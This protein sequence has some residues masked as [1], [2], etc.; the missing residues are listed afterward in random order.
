MLQSI[1][2]HEE[3]YRSRLH[4]IT[5]NCV[6]CPVGAHQMWISPIYKF[7][8][9]SGLDDNDEQ[10]YK[11]I[12]ID[13]TSSIPSFD[14]P[15]DPLIHVLN[16]AISLL[17]KEPLIL[18]FGAGRL[19]NTL[20]ILQKGYQVCAVEFEKISQ[21][22]EHAKE[23]YKNAK[24]YGNKFHK[25]VFPHEFFQTQL[26]FDLILLIN[27]CSIMPVPSER[28]LVLQ[29]CR[30]KLKGNGFVLWYTQHKDP[31]YVSRCV[32]EVKIGDGY[33]MFANRR[34][35]TFYRDFETYEIDEIFLANGYRFYRNFGAG[36][37]YARLYKK[38]GSNPLED[39]LNSQN[40]RKYVKGDMPIEETKETGIKILKHS[41][42]P[43]LNDPY[44]YEIRNEKIYIDALRNIKPGN[45]YASEY[46]NLMLPF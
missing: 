45:K 31:D 7:V 35:Q 43:Q 21:S 18:D 1:C 33:Y 39:V 6:S 12:T 46:H 15:S 19:R 13:V 23:M 38:V 14:V 8:I 42:N 22:T 37:N 4:L 24:S 10:T 34:Y 36:H 27:V 11:E 3:N 28:L 29:Y 2:K 17:P 26:K 41:D 30:T 16:E 5:T 44:P 20:Y 40:I 9:S 32:P 25:L